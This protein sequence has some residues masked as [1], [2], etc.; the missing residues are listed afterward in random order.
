MSTTCQTKVPVTGD[1]KVKNLED[2]TGLAGKLKYIYVDR[3]CNGS[4][5]KAKHSSKKRRVQVTG[6]IK[7]DFMK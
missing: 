6:G 3:Y 4:T 2:F 1:K 7:K 5:N